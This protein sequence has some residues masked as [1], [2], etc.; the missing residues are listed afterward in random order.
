MVIL[1]IVLAQVLPLS[2]RP[3]SARETISYSIQVGAYKDFAPAVEAVGA[4]KA[5][6]LDAFYRHEALAERGPWYYRVFF[7]KYASRGEAEQALEKFK[8]LGGMSDAFVKRLAVA[9]ATA[10]DDPRPDSGGPRRMTEPLKST[11]K[12]SP[13]DQGRVTTIAAD[14]QKKNTV[15]ISTPVRNITFALEKGKRES[16]FVHMD[17]YVLPSVRFPLEGE[18]PELTIRLTGLDDWEGPAEIPIAGEWIKRILTR[19]RPA[20]K[21]LDII[22]ELNGSGNYRLMQDFNRK[23]NIFTVAATAPGID[24]ITSRRNEVQILALISSWQSA[25]AGRRLRNYMDLYH[26]AF[27]SEDM[28]RIAWEQY[29]QK[30]IAG[31]R[32][33]QVHVSELSLRP[34]GTTVLA[35]FKQDYRADAYRD[36]GYKSLEFRKSEGSWKIFRERW[37]SDKPA[38]WPS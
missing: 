6:G 5:R 38:D 3:V 37:F 30:T 10:P 2:V 13:T 36:V 23:D 12:E 29:K 8:R 18:K 34:E 20:D 21:A 15:K 31:C 35:F 26:P 24:L 4:L 32:R 28:D 25:W 27:M 1:P 17:Q 33:I 9:E 14:G 16:I 22:V 7:G 19:F 11:S